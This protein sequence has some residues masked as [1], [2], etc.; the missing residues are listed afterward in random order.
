MFGDAVGQISRPRQSISSQ[1]KDRED[2]A[3]RI[4]QIERDYINNQVADLDK[5]LVEI[6]K[7]CMSHFKDKMPDIIKA[8]DEVVKDET[9]FQ[10]IDVP[11]P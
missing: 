11:F 10:D 1:P 8:I 2:S 7:K 6:Q 9:I 4:K 3:D 5:E